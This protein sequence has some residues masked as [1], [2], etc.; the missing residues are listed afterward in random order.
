MDESAQQ[1]VQLGVNIT[2]FI[3]AL[4]ISITLMLGVRDVAETALEYD[5][6]LPT[7]SRVVSVSET[8]KRVV[9]GDEL[10]AYYAGY[11]SE[12]SQL[13]ASGK[14]LITIENKNGTSRITKDTIMAKN[15]AD[16]VIETVKEF[17]KRKNINI[18]SDY[19]V[20]MTKYNKESQ[21]LEVLLKEI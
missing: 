15:D 12:Q 18:S 21:I 11:M 3:I 16:E 5:A 13:T 20:T 19:E 1:A 10:L 14:F 6:S 2:I 17:F 8:K 9:S 7:G 4:S